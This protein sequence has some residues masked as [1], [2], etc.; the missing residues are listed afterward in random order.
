MS[1][2]LLTTEQLAKRLRVSTMTIRR[3]KK[4]RRI[5]YKHIGPR[6]IRFDPREVAEA[7]VRDAEEITRQHYGSLLWQSVSGILDDWLDPVMDEYDKVYGRK[8]QAR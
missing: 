4:E 7:L 8:A 3:W 2:E 1:A 5:P 6:L